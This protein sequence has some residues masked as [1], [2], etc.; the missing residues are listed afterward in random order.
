MNIQMRKNLATIGVI[1]L[2]TYAI[3]ALAFWYDS[4]L[5]SKG[6]LSGGATIACFFGVYG[7]IIVYQLTG[8][9]L[10]LSYFYL[11]VQRT[12]VA[13][14]ILQSLNLVVPASR[15]LALVGISGGGKSTIF[16]L[17]ERFYDPD[18][19]LNLKNYLSSFTKT[20]T[21]TETE[22]VGGNHLIDMPQ[23][24]A[25]GFKPI[26]P[27]GRVS[28]LCHRLTESIE[29]TEINENMEVTEIAKY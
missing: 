22:T 3:W 18:Q 4:I 6:E 26:T 25:G 23:N 1:Y 13:T 14:K 17:I 15:T 11:F 20:E 10:S 5:V 19:V 21:E 7:M 27:A 29:I 12:V 16:S 24:S 2:V 9:A 28:I 8:L